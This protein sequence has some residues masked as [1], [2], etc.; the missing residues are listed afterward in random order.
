MEHKYHLLKPPAED[1][2]TGPVIWNDMAKECPFLGLRPG[3]WAFHNF[4][5]HHR[6]ALVKADAIR[7]AKN[8]FWIAHRERFITTAFALITGQHPIPAAGGNVLDASAKQEV[9]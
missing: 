6:D 5:R 7:L 2:N 1:W 9:A 8:K 3:R 4:L